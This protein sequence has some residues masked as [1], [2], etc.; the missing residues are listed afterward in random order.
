MGDG[1]H[2]ISELCANMKISDNNKIAQL[3]YWRVSKINEIVTVSWKH[4]LAQGSKPDIY[5]PIEIK[6]QL[7]DIALHTATARD[8][9]F[10]S[11][12]IV[13]DENNNY[14]VLEINSGVMMEK[15]SRESC[16]NY[17]I[18]KSIYLDA[19]KHYFDKL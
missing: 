16:E 10:A 12:D 9:N 17:N 14:M 19:I 6:A 13:V 7:K 15:F 5:L 8:I 18:A 11:I 2:T 3:D 1:V 4:N